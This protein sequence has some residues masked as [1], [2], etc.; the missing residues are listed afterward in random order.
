MEVAQV[1]HVSL[2]NF[3]STTL[4]FIEPQNK[5][6]CGSFW[7]DSQASGQA[8]M[9]TVSFRLGACDEAAFELGARCR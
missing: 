8:Q 3:R 1:A 5:K 9:V 6:A 7:K 4:C 2:L